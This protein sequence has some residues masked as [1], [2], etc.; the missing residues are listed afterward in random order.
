MRKIENFVGIMLTGL[1]VYS[2]FEL[3]F[4]VAGVLEESPT[5]FIPFRI[6]GIVVLIGLL[7]S[8]FAGIF[9]PL[10]DVGKRFDTMNVKEISQFRREYKINYFQLTIGFIGLA[11]WCASSHLFDFWWY[12]GSILCFMYI[13]WICLSPI[14]A[15][16]RR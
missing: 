8:L 12:L 11:S 15:R 3:M 9:F 14:I 13:W 1:F 5:F 16:H 6:N 2:V 10:W 4:N 7:T